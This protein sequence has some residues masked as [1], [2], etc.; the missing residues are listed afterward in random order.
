M[1]VDDPVSSELGQQN[2]NLCQALLAIASLGKGGA[3][4]LDFL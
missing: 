3:D 1:T 2:H 4:I